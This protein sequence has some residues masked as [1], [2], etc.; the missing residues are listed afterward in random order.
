MG[1]WDGVSEFQVSG[2]GFRFRDGGSGFPISDR[3]EYVTV[4]PSVI[5]ASVVDIRF[6]AGCRVKGVGCRV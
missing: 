5:V 1:C 2:W 6:G 3:G 4:D